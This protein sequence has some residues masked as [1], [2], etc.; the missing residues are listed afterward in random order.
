MTAI[1][2]GND[3]LIHWKFDGEHQSFVSLS[4]SFFMIFYTLSKITFYCSFTYH[5]L[6]IFDINSTTRKYLKVWMVIGSFCLFCLMI[7]FVVDDASEERL[8]EIGVSSLHHIYVTMF[9]GHKGTKYAQYC[10]IASGVLDML[11]FFVLIYCY[12]KQLR[13]VA[14]NENRE[15]NRPEVRGVVLLLMVCGFFWMVMV[16]V[17]SGSVFGFLAPLDFISD[18]ICLFL[19]F[20][21]Q[22]GIYQA[23]CSSCD[24]CCFKCIYGSKGYVNVAISDIDVEAL[25]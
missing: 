25:L 3:L 6:K 10:A 22:T 1:V 8:G 4:D 19:M 2:L 9:P 23:L 20:E 16:C 13:R 5:V 11:Y 15:D 14:M 21:A 18:D 17:A 7:A 12:I 24:R